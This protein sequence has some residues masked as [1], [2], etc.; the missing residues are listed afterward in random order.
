MQEEEEAAISACSTGSFRRQEIS[1]RLGVHAT[2]LELGRA[3][4]SILRSGIGPVNA[5]IALASFADRFPI[6]AVLLLG[7]GGALQDH[8]QIGDLVLSRHVLQ[9]DSYSSLQGADIRMRSG[10]YILSEADRAGLRDPRIPAH[11]ELLDWVAQRCGASSQSARAPRIGTILSG[12]EFVGT[13]DRKIAIAALDQEALLVDMEAAGVAHVA[14]RLQIPFLVAKTV[15]DRLNP[16][17]S[18]SSDFTACLRAAAK[19][20]ADIL[21]ALIPHLREQRT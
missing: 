5:G 16:D 13:A 7:V 20:A 10:D 21:A 3:R 15:S 12:N 2:E 8:L 1:G 4:V 9:H 19:N 11:S 17:G 18:I 14:D 6:D